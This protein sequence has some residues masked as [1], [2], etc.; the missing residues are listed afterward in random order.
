MRFLKVV[1]LSRNLS[2]SWMAFSCSHSRGGG[3]LPEI[4]GVCVCRGGLSGLS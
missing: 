4:S 3:V 1:P 2:C